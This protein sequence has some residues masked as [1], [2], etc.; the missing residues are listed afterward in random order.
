MNVKVTYDK[1]L[2]SSVDY[3]NGDVLASNVFV[4]KYALTNKGG[5]FLE[6]TP[7]DMH[8]RIASEFARLKRNIQAH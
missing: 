2:K 1:A 4:T 5:D 3:F 8:K 6:E 7:D